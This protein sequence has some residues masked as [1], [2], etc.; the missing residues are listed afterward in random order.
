[1]KNEYLDYFKNNAEDWVEKA[2]RSDKG[3]YPTAIHRNRIVL[4]VLNGISKY[5]LSILDVGCGA[6]QLSVEMSKLG[7]NVIGVD[8]SPAMLSIAESSITKNAKAEFIESEFSSMQDKLDN[9]KFDVI[10][11]MGF[12]GYIESDHEFFESI[13]EML[14]EGGTLI[15]SCRNRLF[16]LNSFSSY[17]K[18]ELERNSIIELY[19]EM[20]EYLNDIESIGNIDSKFLSSITSA[21]SEAVKLVNIE[22]KKMM[23]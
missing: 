15:V 16:N 20:Q 2:Y 7:H 17:H 22:T 9:K 21:Y 18:Q 4:S 8:Q 5:P 11:A 14:H 10:V 12:I 13:S 3:A 19:D 6:G 1:M 23:I